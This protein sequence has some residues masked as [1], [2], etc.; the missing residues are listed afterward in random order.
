MPPPSEQLV[1]VQPHAEVVPAHP[2]E[3]NGEDVPETR[4]GVPKLEDCCAIC[5]GPLQDPRPFPNA[6][7]PH[8]FCSTCLSTLRR[9]F[10]G[11]EVLCPTCRRPSSLVADQR[12]QCGRLEQLQRQHTAY[13]DAQDRRVLTFLAIT[14]ITMCVLCAVV[15]NNVVGAVDDTEVRPLRDRSRGCLGASFMIHNRWTCAS[16]CSSFA[17]T[18]A[19]A[20]AQ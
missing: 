15:V 20:L 11:S 19:L 16:G 4:E 5:L 14:A 9:H 12:E 18:V 7:C 6:D 13:N 1:L 2:A 10:D 17:S 8:Q 3:A